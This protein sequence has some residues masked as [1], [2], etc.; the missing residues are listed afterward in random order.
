MDSIIAV[1]EEIRKAVND[2]DR[3]ARSEHPVLISG[4]TGTGKELWARAIHLKSRRKNQPFMVVNC[5]QLKNEN[6]LVSELFGHR[7]GSFTDAI[8]DRKGIFEAAEGGT[9]FLDEISE[10]GHEAQ[11]LLLRVLERG[12]FKPLG[13]NKHRKADVRVIAATNRNLQEAIDTG[14]FRNDLYYRIAYLRINLPPLRERGAEETTVLSEYFLKQLN[15]EENTNK[16]FS[17]DVI[18]VLTHHPWPGNVRQLKGEVAHIFYQSGSWEIILPEDFSSDFIEPGKK[19]CKQGTVSGL[20]LQ[21]VEQGRS[22]WQIVKEPFLLREI[23]RSEVKE[24]IRRGLQK[25]GNY[26]ALLHLFLI[27]PNE[28]KKFI[29][30]ISR[31]NLK[32][33]EKSRHSKNS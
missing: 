3:F 2:I 15:N 12:E 17:D 26:K 1:G 14:G 31:H 30:F 8:R 18:N 4:E 16:Q 28:Y 11:A 29:N 23:K 6:L 10:L 21:M 33:D 7:K 25:A 22:F 9:V 27:K 32:P 5:P 24:L 13:E 19:K 20:Y